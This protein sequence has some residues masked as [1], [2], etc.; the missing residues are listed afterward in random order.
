MA[1]KMA[2]YVIEANRNYT[3]NY[4]YLA[5]RTEASTSHNELFKHTAPTTQI[6]TWMSA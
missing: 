5:N 1:I 2:L 4:G 6:A 3:M